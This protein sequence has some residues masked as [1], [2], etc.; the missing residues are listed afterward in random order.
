MFYAIDFG[1]S[2]SLMCA[3]EAGRIHAPLPL[4]PSAEDSSIL[5]S[6]MFAPPPSDAGPSAWTFGSEAIARYES[7]GADGRLLRSIKKYLPDPGFESTV[8]HGKKWNLPEL[9]GAFLAEIK[10][11]ADQYYH[12]DVKSVVLGRPAA[13]SL[14]PKKDQLAEDRLR[15]AAKVAGF[16]TIHFCPEPI[17]AAYTFRKE[18]REPK[19]V[20]VADFGGGT[21]D[22]TVVKLGPQD[23]SMS[24]VLAIGGISVAGDRFDGAIMKHMIAPH[25]GTE[26]RYKMPMGSNELELPKHLVNK[27]CSAPDISFLARQDILNLLRDAQKWSMDEDDA[28]RME[29]LF[30]LVEEHLGY[31]L[32]REI[33]STK[34][35]LSDAQETIFRFDHPGI[36]IEEVVTSSDFRFH[37]AD[38]V[39]RILEA[40][41]Q[42]LAKAGLTTAQIDIVC[43]TGGTAKIP[44]LHLGLAQRFGAEKLQAH[45]HFHSVIGGL[46][47]RALSLLANT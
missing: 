25:F 7:D 9:I 31:K 28:L 17:A 4:D 42:T 40:L 44:A 43:C 47:E 16:E 5:R 20:F 10:L 37:S 45:A 6:V 29:R 13:F 24:D 32:F 1:T 3:I 33:E 22:Y 12:A 21:S 46:G 38:I 23:F 11:R 14:D 39:D 35:S 18:L 15:A 8:I 26:V 19:T 41:D 36:G 34:R 27:L 2:N 30:V